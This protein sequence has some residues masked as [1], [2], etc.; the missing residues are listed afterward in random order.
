M[1]QGLTVYGAVPNVVNLINEM[2]S[3]IAKSRLLGCENEAQGQVMAMACI[4]KGCDPLSLAQRYDIIQGKL[5]MKSDA[6]LAE[7]RSL[8]GGSHKIIER[9]A[10]VA[11]VELTLDGQSQRFRLTWEEAKEE[12]FTKG[13]GGKVKDNYSTPRMRM[14]MLWA[15][16]VSDGVRAMAPEVNTGV[17]TPEEVS[18][19]EE[20]VV[21]PLAANVSSTSETPPAGGSASVDD[22]EFVVK[23]T[24][25]EI[26]RLMDLFTQMQ[27]GPDVQLKAIQ[28]TGARDMGDLSSDGAKQ[29]IAKLETRLAESQSSEDNPTEGNV[30][31]APQL[32]KIKSLC[33]QLAQGD[34]GAQAI[35]KLKSHLE[36][37]GC[38]KF[39]DLS[40]NDADRLI[41]SLQSDNPMSFLELSFEGHAKNG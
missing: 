7:F 38:P 16:V 28:S 36:S 14:Q 29:I 21:S 2:G 11:E 37:Q 41:A 34:G 1:S 25:P 35:D 13:K 30:C 40:A 3:S 23:A 27:I 12:P 20:G 10:D 26:Q 6:M 8:V 19:I 17:Y 9:T 5:S 33:Q 15:R 39:G 4:A 31:D 18:D 22:A 24:G 32:E